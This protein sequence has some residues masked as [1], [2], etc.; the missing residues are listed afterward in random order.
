M[1]G[2]LVKV[3]GGLRLAPALFGAYSRAM[4]RDQLPLYNPAIPPEF[5]GD[6]VRLVTPRRNAVFG[7]SARYMQCADCG[8]VFHITQK[9]VHHAAKQRHRVERFYRDEIV[10]VDLDDEQEQW[11]DGAGVTIGEMEYTA[12]PQRGV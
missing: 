6:P 10:A 5:P 3:W 7:R 8:E 2:A 12:S 1:M 9:A 11:A 4:Q